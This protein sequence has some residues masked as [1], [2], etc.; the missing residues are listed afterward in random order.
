MGHRRDFFFFFFFFLVFFFFGFFFCFAFVFCFLFFGTFLFSLL[1]S[2]ANCWSG[3]AGRSQI[4]P[5]FGAEEPQDL[6]HVPQVWVVM[7]WTWLIFYFSEL[8]RALLLHVNVHP[9]QCW[10]RLGQSRRNPLLESC[11]S[12]CAEVFTLAADRMSVAVGN[13]SKACLPSEPQERVLI[14]LARIKRPSKSC[15]VPCEITVWF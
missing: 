1:K 7:A 9:V 2:S 4:S 11:F 14:Y 15:G 13:Q 6:L 12:F 3:L 5:R 8:A 10:W